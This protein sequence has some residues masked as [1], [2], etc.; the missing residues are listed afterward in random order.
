[1]S[2]KQRIRA[3]HAD[4]SPEP[5]SLK[6]KGLRP[7]LS[8][9]ILRRGLKLSISSDVLGVTTMPLLHR[10]CMVILRWT[11]GDIVPAS[12]EEEVL[13]FY[14]IGGSKSQVLHLCVT[15]GF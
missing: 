12:E 7:L 14:G 8:F 1:M 11:S 13:H 2:G 4:R 15:E 5:R 3:T 6:S 9:V 10:F